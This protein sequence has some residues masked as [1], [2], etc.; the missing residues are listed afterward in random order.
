MLCT[1]KAKLTFTMGTFSIKWTYACVGS[2]FVD[3]CSSIKTWTEFDA[4]INICRKLFV[5]YYTIG[6]IQE[7]MVDT[8]LYKDDLLVLRLNLKEKNTRWPDFFLGFLFVLL[9]K[10]LNFCA[11]QPAGSWETVDQ[12]R[13]TSQRIMVKIYVWG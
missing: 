3:T 5:L 6:C 11:G 7:K 9:K 10:S 12:L 2:N 8:R 1:S 13:M 4:L